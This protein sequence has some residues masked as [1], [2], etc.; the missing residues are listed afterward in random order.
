M[1]FDDVRNVERPTPDETVRLEWGSDVIA[2]VL[3]RLGI[4][5]HGRT[6]HADRRHDALC[7][8]ALSRSY[9]D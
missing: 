2:E 7:D 4:E 3:R 1:N 5:F 6:H 8:W 9:R